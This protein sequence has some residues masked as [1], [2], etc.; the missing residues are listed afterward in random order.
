M[1]EICWKEERDI[2]ENEVCGLL[3]ATMDLVADFASVLANGI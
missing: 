1:S 3:D 2:L